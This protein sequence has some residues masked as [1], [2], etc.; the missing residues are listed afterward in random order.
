MI[1]RK[2]SPLI[3]NSFFL[4]GMRGVG[5]T[6][7]LQN[8]F[9]TESVVTINLLEPRTLANLQANPSL[10][11]P[12]I[13]DGI[14]AK[15][16][17]VI[18]EIQKVPALL[19][20]VHLLIERDGARFALTGSSARKLR[21]GAAN[22][23]AGRAYVLKL[24][25]FLA[26]ELGE[27]FNLHDALEWGL[28]PTIW[29]TTNPIERSLYLQSYAETYI[30]EEII[31]EQIIRNLPP[32]RRFLN[33]ASQMSGKILNY[34]K[35]ASDC[36]TDPSN[37]RNYYQILED[38]LVGFFLEPF[39]QSI[40][41][42]QRESP[43]FYFVDSGIAR[44]LAGHLD[45]PLRPQT[46]LY[47]D[48]FEAFIVN[49]I[50]THLEYSFKQYQ[51]SFLKTKDGAEIDLIIERAGKPTFLIEVKSGSIVRKEELKNLK[52][53]SKDIAG[54][55]PLCLYN[56]TESLRFEEVE[57]VPWQDGIRRIILEG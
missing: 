51:L 22:M 52:N 19:D 5:K 49:Q 37:V 50:R 17:I 40:R 29:K 41:K 44:A 42:R 32:F 28:L 30:K 45:L 15:Q 53:F 36:Q 24:Y 39:N 56:G 34:S 43:K 20:V 35:V 10:L 12:M 54:S 18:D 6:T 26:D 7:L 3:N 2:L 57:C 16:L 48:A 1:T 55:I 33:V 25:P 13:A 47:G 14:A 21:R 46:S 23:L 4:F 31:V 11:Q 27:L 8:F 38:T 9:T